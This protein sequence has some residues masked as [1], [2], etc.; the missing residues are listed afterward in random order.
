M[1][2]RWY[3]TF[4][5]G[6]ALELWRKAMPPEMTRSDTDFIVQQCGLAEGARLLDI[7]C[8]NGRIARE[9]GRRGYRV[10]GIDSSEE[11]IAEA[12]AAAPEI[13]WLLGDM[14]AFDRSGEYDAAF[15]MGNSLCYL[16]PDETERFIGVIA[17]ALAPG[18]TF[19]ADTGTSAESLL[20]GMKKHE[21][22][23]FEDVVMEIENRYHAAWSCLETF[24]TF[25]RGAQEQ[26]GTS[27]HWVYTVR[28]LLRLLERHGLAPGPVLS[29]TAGDP[30]RLGDQRLVLTARKPGM[31]LS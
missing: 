24:Y 14:L 9:L 23:E 17:R 8:G 16:P 2:L 30:F 18:G 6:L 26:R 3:E 13:E 21:T 28:E 20:P 1:N 5:H 27:L 10:T 11:F 15:C 7:P 4:F 25:R 19:V 12:R 29:S 31:I 22:Y